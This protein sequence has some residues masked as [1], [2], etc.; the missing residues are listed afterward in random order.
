M[1]KDLNAIFIIG[2]LTR[3]PE[4]KLLRE[5]KKLCE[6][7]VANNEGRRGDADY[8]SYYNVKAWNRTAEICAEY[9]RKGT[10]IAVTG[11]LT[12][13]RWTDNDGRKRDKV[14]IIADQIQFLARPK[15]QADAGRSDHT[16]H[17][18]QDYSDAPIDDDVIF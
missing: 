17:H 8:V 4:L 9:L 18:G 10:Q 16:A 15:G 12:Q 1:S 11:R 5:D 13:E 6:F 2:R 14:V 7:Q 3:D